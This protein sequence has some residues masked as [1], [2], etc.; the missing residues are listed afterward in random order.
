[1]PVRSLALLALLALPSAAAEPPPDGVYLILDA[2][3]S[4]WGQLPDETA[5]ITV[6]KRVLREFV[7]GDFA[8]RELALRAYGHRRKGDCAD[9]ELVVPFAPQEQVAASVEAFLE[10][11]N[12]L[13]KTPISR[14]LRQALADFGE[15]RGEILL[16]SDGIE[17]CDEDPCALVKAWREQGIP[18]RVHV[19]GLGL[20]EA[21]KTALSCISEAAG[22]EFH[23]AD[24]AA[25]LTAGLAEVRVQA[26]APSFHLE[27][28]DGGSEALRVEG[29]LSRGGKVTYEVASHRRH[30]VEPGTYE[31]SAGVRTKNGS[32]YRPVTRATEV[33]EHG[34][35]RVRV[36]VPVPPRVRAKFLDR[37]EPQRGAAVRAFQD[38]REVF[39]F[40]AIDEVYADEG[41]YE[42]RSQ[43]N[44]EN[45]LSVVVTLAAGDRR[46]I[47]FEM[48]HT[49]HVKLRLIAAGSGQWF[50]QNY[51]LWQG[52]EKKYQV[53]VHNGARVL[54]GTY[55]A[56][57]PSRLTPWSHPGLVV[58]GEAEQSFELT[59]PVGH[60]TFRYQK[61]D[62]SPDTDERLSLVRPPQRSG[63]NQSTGKRIPLTPG[64]YVATGWSHKGDFDP[65]EIEV[66]EGEDQEIVLRPKP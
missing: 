31:L 48:V 25:S 1:M 19:V 28:V 4:M 61:A 8:G 63:K 10:N 62:G 54:P 56:R 50:R 18:I 60:V 43:P 44:P 29:T 24:S 36:E 21:A 30:V 40:R 14:S 7:A 41:S 16:I 46:E 34:E 27:G 38:G 23:D 65:V 51:A 47:V 12:P 39:H 20:D 35:T 9:S 49:V 5:K 11:L 2:S 33:A 53:H 32:L 42:F 22:T 3:G 57:L 64:T 52:G 55:E 17:T 15:R 13:G 26:T 6:A 58:T 66:R 59:V 45:E 37:G